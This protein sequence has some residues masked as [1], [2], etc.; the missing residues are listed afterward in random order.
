MHEVAIAQ[1]VRVRA[2]EMLAVSQESLQ[3][4]FELVA[5]DTPADR[6]RLDVQIV[7]GD[8]LLIDA[9]ELD[10]GQRAL[11]DASLKPDATAGGY[12]LVDRGSIV[13]STI[14]GGSTRRAHQSTTCTAV[15][16]S[17][18]HSHSCATELTRRMSPKTFFWRHGARRQPTAL[19]AAACAPGF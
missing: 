11:V 6:A 1:A 16:C 14:R 4:C 18:L 3:F 17:G 19:I 10:D 9:V 2:G 15:R 8:G 13:E 12:V 5:Q 7:P